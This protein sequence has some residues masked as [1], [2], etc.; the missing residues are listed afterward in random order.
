MA[1]LSVLKFSMADGAEKGLA[2]VQELQ[3]Q[4]LIKLH[5]A[6]IVS[7]PEGAKKPK[8][9]QLVDLTCAGAWDG[10]FWGM[11]FGLIFFVPFFGAAIGG[12]MGA[13]AGHFSD[14]G[15]DDRFINDVRAKVTAG[16]SAL[17]LLTS[18]AVEDR[19]IDAAKTLPKFE[20]VS[21]NLPKD[22]EQKLRD[23]FAS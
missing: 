7:W 9:R 13:L 16:T 1:T 6:A 5:D 10:A 19:V 8:T 14:Y 15:I 3:K 4:S 11:L 20:L 17:F 2:L 22:Q 12:L 23:A 18:D 21:T